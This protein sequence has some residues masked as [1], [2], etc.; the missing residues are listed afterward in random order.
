L[1]PFGRDCFREAGELSAQR[2][3]LEGAKLL[4]HFAGLR[5]LV[6]TKCEVLRHAWN[7]IVICLWWLSF[8]C[9]RATKLAQSCSR[10]TEVAHTN[11]NEQ[12]RPDMNFAIT[13]H[14]DIARSQLNLNSASDTIKEAA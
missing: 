2:K 8:T 9:I 10:H 3:P 1:L 6:N 12:E 13:P 5:G 14:N 11:G 4:T 7:F